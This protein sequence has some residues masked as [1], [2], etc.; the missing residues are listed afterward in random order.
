MKKIVVVGGGTAGWLTALYV[1]R[2][3]ENYEV[4]VIESQDIGI[5]GAGEGSTPHIIALFDFIGI[6][7]SDLVK[8]CD[9]T[10]KNGI[11]FTNWNN[12]N[13]FY[14]HNF[15]TLDN[16]VPGIQSLD[17]DEYSFSSNIPIIANLSINKT[18]DDVDLLRK[19][20]EKNKV[21]FSLKSIL[22]QTQYA[23]PILNYDRFSAFSLHFNASKMA[24]RLKEIG[25]ERNI[26]VIDGIV[27]NIH[28]NEKQF[29]NK[30]VLENETVIDCD[31]VFD[32]TGFNRLIIGKLFNSNWHSHSKYLP[33][34]SAVPFFLK[35]D[36]SIP[37]YTEA[38]AMKYGWIWKIPL[39]SR[40]GCGYVFDSSLISENDAM[41]EIEE[42]LGF[43]PE[44]PRKNKGA[45]KFNAGY[46]NE[47][48]INN[49]VAIGLSSGFIE[50]LE[51]TSIF[52]SILSLKKLIS[53]PN[54]VDCSE[55]IRNEYNSFCTKLNDE[56]VDCIY[57]HYMSQRNDTEFWK[58]FS[59][60]NA[61]EYLKNKLQIWSERMPDKYDDT[62]GNVWGHIS[63][64]KIISG[65]NI[66]REELINKYKEKI[67]QN[68]VWWDKYS[69]LVLSQQK[70]VE[71]C[72]DHNKFLNSL[73][74]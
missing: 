35:I 71:S 22:K 21:P 68:K 40:Y 55:V 30:I 49:C 29:I 69:K 13:K 42:M 62:L 14:Y 33:V 60:D 4:V 47:T 45:F 67:N 9:A 15:A 27:K 66:I 12:D 10:V 24:N 1:K 41:A 57:L 64:L 17:V 44:Y 32:C 63:W 19:I 34:D 46:F 52:V 48:W 16:I 59:Y 26:K 5:L 7:F 3:Y 72:T 2:V 43:E 70:V 8:N 50:P 54:W 6:P 38:I 11:K 28:T 65:I 20:S 18:F 51:A 74:K 73:K 23:D 39:Q 61:P 37:P 56:V 53:N 58:K 36:E 31:F 25:I